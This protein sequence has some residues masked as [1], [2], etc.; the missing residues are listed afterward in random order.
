[1]SRPAPALA[2]GGRGRARLAALRPVAARARAGGA[3]AGGPPGVGRGGARA[4]VRAARPGA[5]RLR[6]LT[7]AGA[8]RGHAGVPAPAGERTAQAAFGLGS[9]R[10][11]RARLGDIGPSPSAQ[12]RD[13][14]ASCSPLTLA[15]SPLARP[16]ESSRHARSRTPTIASAHDPRARAVLGRAR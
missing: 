11:L 10:A 2:R 14:R 6:P 3:G 5:G 15:R 8:A 12:G 13:W 1:R 7:A 16:P 9:V 4:A